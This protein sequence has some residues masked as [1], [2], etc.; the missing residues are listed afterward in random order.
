MAD[1]SQDRAAA[2]RRITATR[3]EHGLPSELRDEVVVEE[4]LSIRLAGE[5]VATT[6]RTP[7][8]DR[9]LALG[10]LFSEGTVRTLSEVAS[11][12]H[13]GR[14]GTPE[15]G[16]V[17]ELT[18]APG[19]TLENDPVARLEPRNP[20]SSACGVCGRQQID[21]L[22]ARCKSL[23]DDDCGLTAAQVFSCCERLAAQQTQFSRT[24]GVHAA[25]AMTA[26]GD[27]V[28]LAEDVGR[29][30]AVDKVVGQMLLEGALPGAGLALVVT[31]RASFEIVQKACAA[32]I[33]IVICL[34]APTTLAIDTAERFGMTLIGFVR[35]STFN[36]YCGQQRLLA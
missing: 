25:A 6:M 19:L 20:A 28:A 13:C 33:P 34:S 30:N 1:D 12:V 9:Q 4:A 26:E 18:P 27:V 32:G 35:G 31:S 23:A 22:A 21:A 17:V 3:V 8:A 29:H 11:V 24:G 5:L 15:F 36:V 10:Y 7:G 14:P 2:T 16:N